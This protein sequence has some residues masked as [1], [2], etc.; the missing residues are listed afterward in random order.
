M[1]TATLSNHSDNLAVLG[2]AISGGKA[3]LFTG[4][5]FSFGS[6]N[7]IGSEPMGAKAL[8][9]KLS[10]ELQIPTNDNLAFTS[11]FYLAHRSAKDLINLLKDNYTVN[12]VSES[13]RTICSFPW[14]RFYTTNYDLIIENAARQSKLN[15]ETVDIDQPLPELYVRKVP[16][17]VHLNG[18]INSLNESALNSSFKLSA[19]S[20]N[21]PDSFIQSDW[22]YL[23]KNDLERASAIVFVGYSLYDIDIQ[24]V[25]FNDDSLRRKTYF[26]TIEEPDI[27]L[28]FTLSKFGHV[29]P[30][31]TEGFASFLK[32]IGIASENQE[33][34]SMQSLNLYELSEIFEPVR[35]NDVESLLLYGDIKDSAVD[36]FVVGDVR[37]PFL[38]DR[39]YLEH[40]LRSLDKGRHTVLYGALGNGKTVILKELKSSLSMKGYNV[41]EVDDLEGDF[42]A[43]LDYL[44]TL[45]SESIIIID[46]Y[47]QYLPILD[48]VAKTQINNVYIVATARIADH[49]YHR[50]SLQV[51]GFVFDEFNIDSLYEDEIETLVGIFE[52]LGYWTNKGVSASQRLNYIKKRNEAQVSLALID[53]LDSPVIKDKITLPFNQLK[54]NPEF[55]STILAICLSQIIG[56]PTT[57]SL[58]S[59]L[60]GNDS[61]YLP[62]FINMQEFRQLFYMKNGEI[63]NS[64]S[65]LAVC[66]IKEHF[67]ASQVTSHLL[68]IAS[69]FNDLGRKDAIQERVFKSMLKFS[70]VERI[71]PR[72][73]KVGNLQRYYE[74]LKV[75]IPWLRN[76]PHFWL[77][78]AMSFI[79]YKKYLKAQ[80][81]LD[82]AY[83]LAKARRDY[84]TNNIDTQQARLWL[85]EASTFS[86][87]NKAYSNFSKAHNL[88]RQLKNDIYKFRQINR[89]KEFY[90]D[91]FSKLPKKS[92][93]TF[94]SACKDI[95]ALI[96]KL[97]GADETRHSYLERTKLIITQLLS[98]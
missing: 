24:R 61:I 22:F 6:K 44:S 30:I 91:N 48:H 62:E 54:K 36:S 52:N 87:G 97:E 2:E 94:F 72:T 28:E 19:S 26:I 11:D 71:L 5:G 59:E 83:D 69:K 46:D 74:D 96:E 1:S 57:K 43:D 53:F 65:I 93:P 86:D 50:D 90:D 34:H 40:V 67:S 56:V 76:D 23:F 13:H 89:Y 82:Q 16:L 84:H 14:R 31:G 85:L 75:H 73:A 63:S 38:I 92:K 81:C 79:A 3:I 68:R 42:V 39:V 58:I 8:S 47:E 60:A 70:F 64:S 9:H 18:S 33:E 32:E 25:L 17:C 12:E 45:S 20:Y 66:I 80:S 7:L 78:Y 10:D 35:D 4:A 15:V 27:E 51:K 95:L 88:L 98:D 37:V 55:E 21:S 77:Q 49:E 29:L 41:Y